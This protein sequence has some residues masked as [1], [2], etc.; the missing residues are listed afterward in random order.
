MCA[1]VL[2][3]TDDDVDVIE[4]NGGANWTILKYLPIQAAT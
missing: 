4:M 2:N 3:Y 1:D